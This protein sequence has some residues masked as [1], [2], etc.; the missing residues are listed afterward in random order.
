MKVLLNGKYCS[1]SYDE[2][3]HDLGYIPEVRFVHVTS[4]G[5][6]SYTVG[7]PQEIRSLYS[8]VISNG[9]KPSRMLEKAIR[10]M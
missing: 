7:K 9:Y 1:M 4:T 3:C 10:T 6:I 2:I 8:A 5:S